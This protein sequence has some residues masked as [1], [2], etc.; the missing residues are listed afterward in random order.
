MHKGANRKP[1]VISL[2]LPAILI[3]C[4]GFYYG[5]LNGQYSSASIVS[6]II[7]TRA[8]FPRWALLISTIGICLGTVLLGHRVTSTI[9][10]DLIAPFAVNLT[11]VMAALMAAVSWSSLTLWLGIPM[12]IS[13]AL[14]GGL[15]GAAWASAGTEAILATG[16]HKVLIGVVLSPFVGLFFGR[17]TVLVCYFLSQFATPRLNIWLQRGQL[18]ASFLMALVYGSN[19]AQKITGVMLLWWLAQGGRITHEAVNIL[20]IFSLFAIGTGTIVGGWR[21]IHTMGSKFYKIRP[22]HGFGAQVSSVAVILTA[23]LYGLPI[24]GSQVVTSAIIGAGSAD[25]LRKVRWLVV[26][27]IVL[28]WLLTIPC[29]AGVAAVIYR[30]LEGLALWQ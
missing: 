4:L 18:T 28:G 10:R 16:L 14:V 9:S 21:I 24:S 13:Q 27:D 8:M 26:Q 15:L 17:Y 20:T 5:Y 23:V 19:E 22:I 1:E 2:T 25:R 12:S 29:S 11:L 3:L 7:S 6:T 30:I